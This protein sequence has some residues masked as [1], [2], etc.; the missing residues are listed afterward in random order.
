MKNNIEKKKN[1]ISEIEL[2][3][4]N[5]IS[6]IL[7]DYSKIKSLDINIIRKNLFDKNII[8]KVLKNNL[9]KKAFINTHNKILN[10][11]LK[12]QILLIFI[13]ENEIKLI[14]KIIKLKN[15]YDEFKIKFIHLYNKLFKNED[16]TY[17]ENLPE[18]PLSLVNFIRKIKLPLIILIKQLNIIKT[19]LK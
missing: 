1:I 19:K 12:G 7:I 14:K 18:K 3:T 16:L 9:A 8:I 13:N 6:T 4:K 10:N 5:T 2:I 17:L 15:E 11:Y